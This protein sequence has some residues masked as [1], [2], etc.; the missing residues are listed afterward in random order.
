MSELCLVC[1]CTDGGLEGPGPFWVHGAA[2]CCTVE[3]GAAET[4]AHVMGELDANARSHSSVLGHSSHAGVEK[5]F[6]VL[7]V[8]TRITIV[9][10]A[11]H[12]LLILNFK[13]LL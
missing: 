6:A 10:T 12:L 5:G 1:D 13:T 7:P 3:V 4:C 8:V 11:K 9:S 2:D